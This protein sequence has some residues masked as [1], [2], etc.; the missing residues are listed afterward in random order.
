MVYAPTTYSAATSM[1]VVIYLHGGGGDS[2]AAFNEGMGT[3]AEQLGFLLAA[4]AG[5]NNAWN[6]GTW[7]GGSCCGSADDV[8]FIAAMITHI[9]QHYTVDT[10]RIYATGISNGGLMANRLGCE[11]S[12][13]IAA[14]ATV[15]PAARP[16]DCAP[17]RAI[18]VLDIH[19]HEDRCNPYNG[20]TP[21]FSYCASVPYTRMSA[22][23]M[24]AYWKTLY[25]CGSATTVAY[26]NGGATCSTYTDCDPAN[27]FQFC[28]VTNMGHTWPSGAQYLSADL[29]GPV[30]TDISFAQMWDFL[31]LHHL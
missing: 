4:P 13:T 31:S 30:S 18:P 16:S 5:S 25:S 11:L 6:G 9:G 19:G 29:I 15:A 23:E 3:S 22:V 12:T 8:G 1:P 26:Q 28:E 27:N 10:T 20:G 21:E 14:I 17:T 24:Q 2:S 7:E